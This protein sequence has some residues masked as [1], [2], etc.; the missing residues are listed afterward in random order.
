MTTTSPRLWRQT[1]Y[2]LWLTSDTGKGLAMTLFSF[3]VPLLAL[4]ITND[5][6]KAGI[7]AAVGTIVRLL[8]TLTGGVLADRHRRI[9]MMT[10]GAAAGVLVAGAFTAMALAGGIDFVSLLLFEVLLAGVAGLFSPAGEAALKD[11]V[12]G[13]MMGRAQAANQGRDAALQ[14]A[15]GP[16]GGMLL[17]AGGW[18]IGAAMV[19]SSLVSAVAAWALGRRVGWER[20]GAADAAASALPALPKNGLRE[21]REG[22]RWLFRRPDLSTGT[23]VATVINL[24][25]NAGITTMIYSVL[26]AGHSEATIG[27]MMAASGAAMLVGALLAPTLVPRIGAGMLMILGLFACTAAI[28]GGVFVETPWG[29]ALL[30]SAAVFLIPAL[31]AAFSGYLMVATPTALVGRVNS[32][33]GVLSMGAMPLSP[34]IAGFGLAWAG[35]GPTLIFSLALCAIALIMGV[36]SRPLRSIPAE[37]GWVE[38]AEQYEEPVSAASAR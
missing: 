36:A 34:L 16:I 2:L 19:I 21:L 9:L 28:A 37:A 11:I 38:H 33:G 24:G 17:A 32:V 26:Q 5:P 6:A 8:A 4:V 23:V 1:P 31:N 29:V 10:L 12:P 15:G 20:A 13:E 18:L 3:A 22:V 30:I 25:L 35:R 14:L 27:W 7:I